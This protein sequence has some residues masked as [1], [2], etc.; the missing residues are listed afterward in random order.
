[1]NKQKKTF[2]DRITEL[3]EVYDISQT[4]ICNKTGILKS[5]MSMYMN[6]KH[7]PKQDT[8]GKISEAYS[9]DPA[10]IMGY[11]VPMRRRS[12]AEAAEEDYLLITK[13]SRLTD[14]D[15]RLIMQTIDSMIQS[16]DRD[17]DR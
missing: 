11:D 17:I 7:L 15:Q 5:S 9:I 6:G 13:F 2:K 12:A 16:Y 4:D 3:M 10:W 1:M 14:R 8:I